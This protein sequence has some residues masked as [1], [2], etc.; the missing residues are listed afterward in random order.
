MLRLKTHS[1]I[2]ED[3]S[4]IRDD[5]WNRKHPDRSTHDCDY[6]RQGQ[7]WREGHMEI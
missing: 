3:K 1:R 4:K 5:K 6:K 7:K 2:E